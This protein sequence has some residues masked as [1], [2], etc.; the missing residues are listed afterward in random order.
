MWFFL[1]NDVPVGVGKMLAKYGHTWTTAN[2]AHLAADSDDELT[3]YADSRRAV[4]VTLDKEFSR[5]RRRAAIGQHVMLRCNEPEAA[6]V[7]EDQLDKVC[8]YL[9]GRDHVMIRVSRDFVDADSGWDPP[10]L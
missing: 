3:V 2:G 1:D 5:R 4:L 9:R 6:G 10:P 8:E 7:L